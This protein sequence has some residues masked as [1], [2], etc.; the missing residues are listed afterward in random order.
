MSL[1]LD[2]QSDKLDCLFIT[3]YRARL[4]IWFCFDSRGCISASNKRYELV[5]HTGYSGGLRTSSTVGAIVQIEPR[6]DVTSFKKPVIL[7]LKTSF[8]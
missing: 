2:N 8:R 6:W 7:S 5:G 4:E 3:G 1:T